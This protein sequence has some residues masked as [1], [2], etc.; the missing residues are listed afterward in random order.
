MSRLMLPVVCL[1]T[2]TSFAFCQ[3]GADALPSRRIAAKR[4]FTEAQRMESE[5]KYEEAISLLE[6]A[7]TLVPNTQTVEYHLGLCHLQCG[8]NDQAITYFRKTLSHQEHTAEGLDAQLKVEQL[9]LPQLSSLQKQRYAEATDMLA[10]AEELT[11]NEG[12]FG[13]AYICATDANAI[14]NELKNEAPEY[15]P[16]YADMGKASLLIGDHKA[17]TSSFESY[18]K[19]WSE[20]EIMPADLR[21]VKVDLAEARGNIRAAERNSLLKSAREAYKKND[22]RETQGLMRKL[23]SY[24]SHSEVAELETALNDRLRRDR[25]Q[26]ASQEL[27]PQPLD[28]HVIL[29]DGIFQ[30]RIFQKTDF[31]A[32]NPS[33]PNPKVF[34]DIISPAQVMSITANKID[35]FHV[36]VIDGTGRLWHMMRKADGTWL[37]WGNVSEQCKLQEYK[38]HAFTQGYGSPE[39]MRWEMRCVEGEKQGVLKVKRTLNGEWTM[40]SFD[41]SVPLFRSY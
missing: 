11:I 19:K 26:L 27:S 38:L 12:E 30:H 33:L 10:R 16:V 32:V 4:C 17:A 29:V 34:N 8:R 37:G 7:D 13:P 22:F 35:E 25:E 5:E 20:K 3:E 9:L 24:G 36:A 2:L 14:L 18:I 15:L 39:F 1:L 23:S 31:A 28:H 6:K 21:S 41:K 40:E